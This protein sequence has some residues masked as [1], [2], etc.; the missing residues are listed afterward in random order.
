VPDCGEDAFYGVRNR[1]DGF[2]AQVKDYRPH[3]IATVFGR[4]VLRLPHFRCAGCGGTE[5]GVDW[6]SHCRSTPELDQLRTHLSA[7]MPYRIAAGLLEHLLRHCHINSKC[8]WL[9]Q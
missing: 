5:A 1:Y 8:E 2:D 6:L 9:V 4:V 7:L 3:Q